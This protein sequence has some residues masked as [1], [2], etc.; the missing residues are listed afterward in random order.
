MNIART[1]LK[2]VVYPYA[3]S[4]YH[5]GERKR[6]VTATELDGPCTAF[7]ADTLEEEVLW[8]G[9]GGTMNTCQLND[10]GDFLAIQQFYKGF[11]SRGAQIVR[12]ENS[13]GQWRQATVAQLPFLHRFA[14]VDV[15]DEK[16]L[17]CCILCKDKDSK[18]DWS[19]AGCV[20]IARL[21]EDPTQAPKFTTLIEGIHRNHGLFTGTFQGQFCALV[22]GDEGVFQIGIPTGKDDAWSYKKIIDRPVSDV[23]VVD[24]DG[25]GLDELVTIEPFHGGKIVVNHLDGDHWTPVYQYPVE[26]GHAIWSGNFLGKPSFIIGYRAGNAALLLFHLNEKREG[27]WMMDVVMLDEHEGPTNVAVVHDGQRERI[28]ACSGAKNRIVLYDVTQEDA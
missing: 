24:L 18:E 13:N 28:F 15:A 5:C 19:Q 12:V 21:P 26:F 9:H 10:H 4:V 1:V 20:Q 17:I 14:L 22:T 16:F 11:N 8:E 3:V 27:E 23:T 25:D 6:V 2:E 7:W